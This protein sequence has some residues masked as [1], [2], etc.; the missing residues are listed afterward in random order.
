MANAAERVTWREHAS[1]NSSS[2][3]PYEVIH[4]IQAHAFSSLLEIQPQ[5]ERTVSAAGSVE[6]LALGYLTKYCKIN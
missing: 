4:V 2:P 5:R 3:S 1:L 6:W